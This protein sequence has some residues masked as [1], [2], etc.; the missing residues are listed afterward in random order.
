M[1]VHERVVVSVNKREM[2]CACMFVDVKEETGEILS[3]SPGEELWST[4]ESPTHQPQLLKGRPPCS[5]KT[6]GS[7]ECDGWV[8]KGE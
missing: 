5:S 6:V 3:L 1:C 2:R 4:P 7:G 8:I